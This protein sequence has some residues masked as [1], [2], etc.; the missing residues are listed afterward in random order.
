MV[1]TVLFSVDVGFIMGFPSVL[2]PA[3]ISNK[4]DIYATEDEA[5]WIG[6]TCILI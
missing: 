6:M 3:L 1:P 5:S 2:S 4:T